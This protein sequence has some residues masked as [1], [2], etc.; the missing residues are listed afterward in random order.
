MKKIALLS[1]ALVLALGA[2]GVG[3]AMWSD[4]VTISGSVT[5][6]TVTI[7]FTEFTCQEMFQY[8]PWSDD[9]PFYEG[10]Y[11]DKDVATCTCSMDTLVEDPATTLRGYKVGTVTVTNGYPCYW[12]FVTFVIKNLGT[13]PVIIQEWEPV[14]PDKNLVWDANKSSL[15]DPVSGDPILRFRTVNLV[16]SQL[17]QGDVDKAEIDVHVEQAAEQGH[18]YKFDIVI[19]AIQW[20]ESP[21]KPG[22]RPPQPS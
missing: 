4:S 9:D 1:L 11:E 16:G 13:T 2:L 15:C 6:N 19:N 21:L 14:D 3:Y 22:V 10:E 8:L 7:G 12:C 18:Q 20:N 17:H 5:T